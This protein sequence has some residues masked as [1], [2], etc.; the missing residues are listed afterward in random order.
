[1]SS[2]ACL[3]GVKKVTSKKGQNIVVQVGYLS[4]PSAQPIVTKIGIGCLVAK[5]QFDWF[6][7]F[8]APDGRISL[9]PIDLRHHPYNSYELPCYT[10]IVI[11]IIVKKHGLRLSVKVIMVIKQHYNNDNHTVAR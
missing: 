8:R 5:F 2:V 1:M 9:A 3:M 6:R 10:V 11:I 4:H 7:C